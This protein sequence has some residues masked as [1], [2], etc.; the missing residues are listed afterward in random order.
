MFVNTPKSLTQMKKEHCRLFFIITSIW[1]G[2][3]LLTK[4]LA[5]TLLDDG[6]RNI[7]G[8]FRLAL[9]HNGGLFL[10]MFSHYGSWIGLGSIIT[11]IAAPFLLGHF[12]SKLGVFLTGSMMGGGTGNTIGKVFRDGDGL[13][14]G[15]VVDFIQLGGVATFNV[16]DVGAAIGLIG[17]SLMTLR[18][19]WNLLIY[20]W[21]QRTSITLQEFRANL[22]ASKQAE[23]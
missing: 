2:L 10:G 22:K 19:Q 21:H 1:L 18:S 6:P 20:G 7:V 16:A 11:L 17:L 15:E 3:D 23:K 12:N 14:A 13:L 9:E 8:D 5:L 4:Q